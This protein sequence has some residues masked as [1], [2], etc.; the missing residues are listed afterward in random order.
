MFSEETDR[1]SLSLPRGRV[2]LEMRWRWTLSIPQK[3]V[4]EVESVSVILQ[5]GHFSLTSF[6]TLKKKVKKKKVKSRPSSSTLNDCTLENCRARLMVEK[7][8]PGHTWSHLATPGY[9]C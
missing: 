7:V 2:T 1:F 9:T 4:Y 6:V 8:T 3:F 5:K